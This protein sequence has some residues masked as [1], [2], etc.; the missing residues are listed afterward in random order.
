MQWWQ[1]LTIDDK[2]KVLIINDRVQAIR[3][4]SKL[5]QRGD[6]I[7][8][9]GKGHETYQLVKDKVLEMDDRKIIKDIIGK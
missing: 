6:I 4:A 5:A 7:L 8:V 1:G 3:T 2:A 9:A